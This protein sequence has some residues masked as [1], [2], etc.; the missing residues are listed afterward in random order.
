M[1]K[2]FSK[3][4]LNTQKIIY[5]KRTKTLKDDICVKTIVAKKKLKKK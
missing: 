4:K 2:N 1:D 3:F 5:L